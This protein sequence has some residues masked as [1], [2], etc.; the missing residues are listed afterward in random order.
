[1][2]NKYYRGKG[3]QR[4]TNRYRLFWG[5]KYTVC[6]NEI[7]MLRITAVRLGPTAG[8]QR[9]KSRYIG[10][11]SYYTDTLPHIGDIAT[12]SKKI[13]IFSFLFFFLFFFCFLLVPFAIFERIKV[14]ACLKDMKARLRILCLEYIKYIQHCRNRYFYTSL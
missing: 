4:K 11:S 13:W 12:A 7:S 6:R 8:A 1:M 14:M 3:K 5:G 9:Y 10:F 2:Y